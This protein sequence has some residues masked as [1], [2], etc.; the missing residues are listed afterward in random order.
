MKDTKD[1]LQVG[2]TNG[3]VLG[4]SIT[5]CNEILLMISTIL[6]IIFTIYKFI[7]LSKK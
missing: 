6:A 7:K 1:L 4:L 2:L 3:G 5:E